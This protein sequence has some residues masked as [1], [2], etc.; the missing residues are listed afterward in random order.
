[1]KRFAWLVLFGLIPEG[2]CAVSTDQPETVVVNGSSTLT[3]TWTVDGTSDPR[4]CAAEAAT[5]IDL[6][7]EEPLETE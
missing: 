4:A 7:P 6:I 5:S 3:V 1:M 2:G